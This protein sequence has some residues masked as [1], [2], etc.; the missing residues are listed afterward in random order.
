MNQETNEDID[1]EVKEYNKYDAKII[2]MFMQYINI[3]N[4]QTK[5][6]GVYN[7]NKFSLNK[8][9]LKYGQ[10]GKQVVNKEISQLHN[11]EVF[12]PMMLSK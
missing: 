3:V 12:K 10:K 7:T 5:I 1:I 11:R 9:I 2:P 4:N 8:G 6:A